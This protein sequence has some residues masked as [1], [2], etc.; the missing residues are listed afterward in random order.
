MSRMLSRLNKSLR[1]RFDLTV[2]K[3]RGVVTRM[4]GV[5]VMETR[6]GLLMGRG[7]RLVVYGKLRLGANVT[8]SD[9]CA[10]EIGPHGELV[11]ADGTFV[12]RGTVIRSDESVTIG[13]RCMLAEHCSVRDQD[14]IA[15]PDLRKHETASVTSPIRLGENVWVGAG[16]RILRGAVLGDG[17]VVAANT[18]IRSQFPGGVVVAGVPGRIVKTFSTT[19]GPGRR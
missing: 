17:A 10:L 19:T 15:D 16:A 12:G 13:R 14:H 1:T 7:V 18:V 3:T 5:G 6:P 4:M 8:L 11:L 9:G 2:M